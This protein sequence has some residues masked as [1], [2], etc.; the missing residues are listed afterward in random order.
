MFIHGATVDRRCPARQCLNYRTI[1]RRSTRLVQR[2]L[3]SMTKLPSKFDGKTT[4]LA[5]L[6]VVLMADDVPVA[7]IDDP[8]LWQRLLAAAGASPPSPLLP[9]TMEASPAG[10]IEALA[11]DIGVESER[12][13]GVMHP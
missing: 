6:R 4:M 1:V 8:D 3:K 11:L 9:L 7:E 5:R 13:K 2:M 10:A 12:L